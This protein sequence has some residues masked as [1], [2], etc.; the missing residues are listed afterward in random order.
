MTQPQLHL[1]GEPAQIPA[2][3]LRDFSACYGNQRVLKDVSLSV[4][5]RSVTCLLG[6]SGSGKSTLIR[7]LNRI[8]DAL[9]G[10]TT[11]GQVDIHG[12]CCMTDFN[13][14]T[15]LRAKVGMVFQTPCV[16]PCSIAQN[17]LFGVRNRK[18]S[19][20]EKSALV[21][22]SL[23]SAALWRDV[24]DRLDAPASALS[25][26]QQQRLCIARALAVTPDILLLD[27]P[28]ASVDPVSAREIEALIIELKTDY[29]IIM[30]THDVRQAGRVADHAIFLCDGEIIEQGPRDHMFSKAALPKTRTYFL[31]EFCDC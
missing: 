23:R 3:E 24:S 16:F 17:V 5:A 1:V 26:G 9:P 27:E 14:I 7:S 8:N 2:I 18:L 15:R 11:S 20:I 19:K 28:T 13:D 6:P 10:F 30:V 4:P 12:E 22:K 21:E 31:E 25:V 29:T